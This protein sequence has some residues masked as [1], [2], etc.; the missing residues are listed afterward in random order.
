ML[1]LI[2][3]TGMFLWAG[4]AQESD[5]AEPVE[6]IFTSVSIPGDSHTE[7]MYVFADKV[8]ELTGGSV[9]VKVYDSANSVHTG[10]RIRCF[11]QRTG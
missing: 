6:L 11:D 8:K 1:V 2:L 7:A 10:K 4:G 3:G 5:E 9:E